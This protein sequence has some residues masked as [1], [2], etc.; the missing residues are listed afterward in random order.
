MPAVLAAHTLQMSPSRSPVSKSCS[1]RWMKSLYT[2][3]QI[4]CTVYINF[5]FLPRAAIWLGIV[6][7]RLRYQHNISSVRAAD[8]RALLSGGYKYD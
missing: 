5:S 2:I 6:A 1:R 7:A 4:Y 8:F 3:M